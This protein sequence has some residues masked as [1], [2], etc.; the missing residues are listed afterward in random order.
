MI[1]ALLQAV[2]FTHAAARTPDLLNGVAVL[3]NDA[4]IT[5]KDIQLAL[6]DDIELLERQFAGRP[7]Q[8]MQKAAELERAKIEELIENQL[9]LQ[10]FKRAGYVIPESYFQSRLDE[11]IRKSYGDR[12]TLTKT[13]QAQ[14]LTFEAYR[15]RLREREI[16]RLM[17][18]QRVPREPLISP[19]KIENYYVQN[20]DKFKQEDQVKLRMIVLTNSPNNRFFSPRKVADEIVAKLDQKVPFEELARIYSQELQADRGGERPYAKTAL[21]EDIARV[22]FQLN[23]GEH[24][25]P[26]ETPEGIFIIKLEDKKVAYIQSLAEVRDEIENTLRAEEVNRLRRQW[27]DQLRSKALIRYF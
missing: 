26:I 18:Q 22:A 20:R 10:E 12:L 7:Q 21:R 5:I 11:E 8:F 16:L 1:L 15:T 4:V 25:R 3:V 17:W 24:S 27:I 9:V 6:R 14:G 23:P 13:L 19:T 2:V